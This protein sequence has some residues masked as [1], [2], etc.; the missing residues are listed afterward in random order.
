MHFTKARALPW[1]TDVAYIMRP[2][3]ASLIIRAF[4]R[5]RS[6][7]TCRRNVICENYPIKRDGQNDIPALQA[8]PCTDWHSRQHSCNS[9]N[10]EQA[11]PE[12]SAP[13][14]LNEVRSI[15]YTSRKTCSLFAL[16][17]AG[18]T[19]LSNKSNN[20]RYAILAKYARSLHKKMRRKTLKRDV[21]SPGHSYCLGISAHFPT[22]TSG[23]SKNA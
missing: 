14:A 6:V 20:D 8:G 17:T 5:S 11:T 2:I 3:F 1:I 22:P 23:C 10:N 7:D 4:G 19:N 13:L 21:I 12:K 9:H 18:A 16:I 15:N